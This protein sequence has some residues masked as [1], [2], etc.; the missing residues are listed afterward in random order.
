MANIID[1]LINWKK[2]AR[3]IEG[4]LRLFILYQI[5]TQDTIFLMIL[6]AITMAFPAFHQLLL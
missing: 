1:L 3:K 6:G 4:I 2:V 5:L